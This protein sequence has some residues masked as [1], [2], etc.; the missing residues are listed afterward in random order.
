MG[1]SD[2]AIHFFNVAIE[3]ARLE[4]ELIEL[5]KFRVWAVAQ[6]FAAKHIAGEQTMTL[7]D[8]LVQLREPVTAAIEALPKSNDHVEED[9][10]ALEQGL[11][12]P[13]SSNQGLNETSSVDALPKLTT[14]WM[15]SQI[16]G[17]GQH[18]E[19]EVETRLRQEN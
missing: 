4:G 13:L 7:I 3:N 9:I 15:L 1:E 6:Q 16:K 11:Y 19:K 17:S 8:G 5:C 12:Q 10:R 14:L 2:K 18:R